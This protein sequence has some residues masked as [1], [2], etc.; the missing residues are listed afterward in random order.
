MNRNAG[1]QEEIKMIHK[2]LKTAVAILTLFL[3]SFC[4]NSYNNHT[5][6][7]GEK[8]ADKKE[9]LQKESFKIQKSEEEWQSCLTPEQY[10]I[11][12]EKGTEAAFT[13]KFYNFHRKGTYK[14]AACGN[15]LFSSEHKYD[16]GTGWSSFWQAVSKGSV[17]EASDTSLFMVRT[18]LQCSHCSAHL[19]HLFE[20]GP[21]PTGQRFCINSA[22]LEFDERQ[23]DKAK[24]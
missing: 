5:K 4:G 23:S 14:C 17:K 20:D 22:S 9:I 11:M 21:Q 16:S 18:E 6:K 3:I 24:K 1:I 15:E 7:A 13:G 19:G 2:L 8:M 12:R 10:K